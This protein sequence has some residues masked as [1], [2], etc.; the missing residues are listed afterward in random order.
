MERSELSHAVEHA[1]RD[2]SREGLAHALTRV[3]QAAGCTL[4]I[5]GRVPRTPDGFETLILATNYPEDWLERYARH[6]LH[7]IDP[8]VRCLSAC[9]LPFRWSEAL[10]MQGSEPARRRAEAM[11]MDAARHGLADGWTFPIG[12]RSGLLGAAA[13]GGPGSYDWSDGD[14]A[15]VWGAVST[16]VARV[17]GAERL[18]R[19]PNEVPTVPRREREVLML[20]SEGLTS[21]AIADR[22]DIAVNT[23]DWHI[24]QLTRRM[25]ARNRQHLLVLAMRAGLIV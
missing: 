21:R 12:S 24:V 16:L 25:G 9:V 19:V 6:R 10:R 20:L 4:F 8:T 7:L 14:V 3:A 23:V 1:G 17:L 13:L 22:L 5:A 2:A 18:P 15:L 11:M